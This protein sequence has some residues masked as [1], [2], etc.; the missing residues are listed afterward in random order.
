MNDFDVEIVEVSCER[1][2]GEKQLKC[3]SGFVATFK[4]PVLQ[5]E[6]IGTTR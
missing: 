6:S 3:V 1:S 5:N 4:V 2:M